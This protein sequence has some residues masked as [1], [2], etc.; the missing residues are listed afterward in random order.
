MAEGTA[1]RRRWVSLAG[2]GLA[3]VMAATAAEAQTGDPD[4][5]FRQAALDHATTIENAWASVEARIRV[6]DAGSSPGLWTSEWSGTVAPPAGSWWLQEWT[7]RGLTARYCGGTLAVYAAR[8]ELKGVG[9]NQRSVQVAPTVDGGNRD[10]LH[11]ITQGSRLYSGGRGRRDGSLPGCMPIPSTT[12]D[13]VGLV[14][15][16]AD[17]RR[18]PIGVR[19]DFEEQTVP[20]PVATDVGS[21]TQRRL[22]RVQVTAVE[23]CGPPNCEDLA[24]QAGSPPAW[25]ATCSVRE[26]ML[27][28]T[29]PALPEKARCGDWFRWSNDCQIVWAQ[30]TPTPPLPDPV[31]TYEDGGVYS[32][33]RPCSCPSGTTGTCRLRY[34]RDTEYRVFTLRPGEPPVRTRIPHRVH[35]DVR[36][37]GR[38]QNCVPVVTPPPCPPGQVDDG[39]GNCVPAVTPPQCT[40]PLVDDGNGNCVTPVTTPTSGTDAC[41]DGFQGIAT[42]TEEPGE[43]RV[44]DYSGCTPEGDPVTEP[45][46][47]TDACPT[48]WTGT[49][50]WT[51]EP[52]EARVYDYTA[53]TQS[54]SQACPAG[55]IGTVTWTQAWGQPQEFDYSACMDDPADQS[56][57]GSEACPAPWNG[58][59]TWTQEP[60]EARVYDY[61]GCSRTG[62]GSCPPRQVG[63]A[64]WTQVY[65]GTQQWNYTGCTVEE[66]D[67]PDPVYRTRTEVIP[68]SGACPVNYSGTQSWFAVW[69]VREVDYGDGAGWQEASRSY[70][71]AT[72]RDYS[73]CTRSS[74]RVCPYSWNGIVSLTQVYGQPWQYDYS[75]CTRSGNGLCLTGYSGTA[76][77]TQ[78]WG[79][80]RVWDYSSCTQDPT[81]G[82]ASCL[83]GF[84]GTASWTQEP[85]EA[86]VWDYSGCSRTVSCPGGWS[87]TARQTG[88][89]LGAVIDYSGCARSGNGSCEVGYSGTA[90]FTQTWG[91]DPV[92]DY[93]AC[94]QDPTSGTGSCPA[95]W[96]GQASW[97][98]QPGEARI[99]DYSGCWREEQR[100]CTPPLEG[101]TQWRVPWGAGAGGGTQISQN[102]RDCEGDAET[103]GGCSSTSEQCTSGD[104]SCQPDPG[105]GPGDV[106]GI[107]VD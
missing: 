105:E 43:D 70:V 75:G 2:A 1:M 78:V 85:G 45:A 21:L 76:S 52:D 69:E 84:T 65:G 48:P 64:S 81:S 22:K 46:S 106:G 30:A 94:T 54:G 100:G 63:E 29:P 47:G 35:G 42:W 16:V 41:P 73:G 104:A 61:S 60:G 3:L 26:T 82:T 50:S 27:S 71:T 40:P 66:P 51:Q 57:S 88:V 6:T 15:S 89:G 18:T 28:Q 96:N 53:C 74:T 91:E 72:D 58:T 92:W 103:G 62:V 14:L 11:L 99:W 79:E 37:V 95:G 68:E 55:Q 31:I 20:C 80:S 7:D 102:C 90:T 12:G 13:R 8:D 33:S 83:A 67:D 49:A 25:P 4:R 10:G 44:Y 101:T 87:G 97:T 23:N 98:Q 24:V 39:N 93:S 36:F 5:L 34:E 19:W 77:W 56:Q 59:A 32:W 107:G 9:R 86:R 17:P 38:S